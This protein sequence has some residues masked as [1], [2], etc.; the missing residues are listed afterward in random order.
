M[1]FINEHLLLDFVFAVQE[2]HRINT[3]G[4]R[5]EIDLLFECAVYLHIAKFKDLCAELVE[6][7]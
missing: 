7:L 1:L 3:A 5:A 2:Y 4:N 6:H